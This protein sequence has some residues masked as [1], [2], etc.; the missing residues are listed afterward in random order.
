M[1]IRD[2]LANV[3]EANPGAIVLKA[4]SPI[5]VAD[6]DLVTDKRVLVI[7][8]GPTL[9]HG[10]MA[11]GAGVIAARD[12]GAAELIDPRPFAVGSIART[13]EKFTHIGP[14]LPAMGYG[15]EQRAELAET[16]KRAN[17]DTV[18]VA[19]PVNLLPLLDLHMPGTRVTYGIEIVD[20]PSL[21]DILAGI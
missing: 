17:P 12:L 4:N 9:T 19:T 7:E 5:T 8:D 11:Y 2:R 16:I 15:D 14:L 13:F 3:R 18:V 10:S 1:C 20:G 6:P 21:G